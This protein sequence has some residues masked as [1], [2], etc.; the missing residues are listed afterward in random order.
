M[1]V[2]MHNICGNFRWKHPS[3]KKVLPGTQ[4]V[5]APQ[6]TSLS[7]MASSRLAEGV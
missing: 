3:T 2:D 6:A 1:R 4:Q 7:E 5:F